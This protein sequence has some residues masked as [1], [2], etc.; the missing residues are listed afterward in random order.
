V[1]LPV[2]KPIEPEETWPLRQS[3]LRPHQELHEMEWPH[4][5]ADGAVH[6]GAFDGGAIVGVASLVP[7][8]EGEAPLRLRGMAVGSQHRGQGI[9][10]ALLHACIAHAERRGGGLWCNARVAVEPFYLR[11]GFVRMR[12]DPFDVPGVGPH[13]AMKRC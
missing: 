1:A 11:A 13:V 5:R 3:V 2:V 12:P 10:D 6:F 8:A 7:E 4:D 9:G